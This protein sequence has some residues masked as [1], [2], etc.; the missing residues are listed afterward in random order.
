MIFLK[1][2]LANASFSN[3]MFG[4]L[5]EQFAREFHEFTP[6][7]GGIRISRHSAQVR[8]TTE[9]TYAGVIMWFVFWFH[10]VTGNLAKVKSILWLEKV[11]SANSCQSSLNSK[12]DLCRLAKISGRLVLIQDGCYCF[13]SIEIQLLTSNPFVFRIIHRA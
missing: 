9:G 2:L 7:L 10:A 5:C 3:R 8:P 11:L 6:T 13:V 12:K 1:T 4:D